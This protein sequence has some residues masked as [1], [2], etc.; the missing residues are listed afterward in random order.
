MNF[1]SE[2]DLSEYACTCINHHFQCIFIP[3]S[4]CVH[5]TSDLVN[6]FSF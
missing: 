5:S 3:V 6:V 1:T 2:F 4:A